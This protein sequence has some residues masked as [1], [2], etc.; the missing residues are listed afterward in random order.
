MRSALA[1]MSLSCT[2]AHQTIHRNLLQRHRS[3]LNAG[4]RGWSPLDGT[5]HDRDIIRVQALP[6]DSCNETAAASGRRG[7]PAPPRHVTA[8]SACART[9]TPSRC[10]P[11][12]E[13]RPSRDGA[14]W[15]RRIC[16]RPQR[17]RT[18]LPPRRLQSRAPAAVPASPARSSVTVITVSAPVSHT[19]RV[20]CCNSVRS[21]LG[22][23]ISR[24]ARGLVLSTC[25]TQSEAGMQYTASHDI[26]T[27]ARP[28]P[29]QT[30]PPPRECCPRCERSGRVTSAMP[31]GD[32][33][34][35]SKT[36]CEKIVN[37]QVK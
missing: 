10:P 5:A 8:R 27:H 16:Q 17:H 14:H 23:L 24:S 35:D 12:H 2:N 36:H 13:Q 7:Q 31:L 29:I 4:P 20:T 22:F 32:P 1:L 30:S 21:R 34:D 33:T 28:E 6:A 26:P 15:P 3:P 37:N 11:E 25:D 18:S 19:V 9:T